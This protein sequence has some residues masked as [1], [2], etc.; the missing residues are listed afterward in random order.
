MSKD[1]PDGSN[2]QDSVVLGDVLSQ[3]GRMR[4]KS[5]SCTLGASEMETIGYTHRSSNTVFRVC[6][7]RWVCL[8]NIRY[9]AYLYSTYWG[10]GYYVVNSFYE[11]WYP[12][13]INWYLT[14]SDFVSSNIVNLDVAEHVFRMYI[15]GMEYAKPTGWIHKPDSYFTVDDSTPAVDQVVVFTE[16]CSYTPT[17]W[18]WAFGDGSTSNEQNPTHAYTV[19]GTYQA[20]L[21]A[22]NAGGQDI[23]TVIITVT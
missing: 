2:I 4:S 16:G 18:F 10:Y 22:T 7:I 13:S 6:G 14:D 3:L 1:S 23:H 19:A 8:D 5:S 12:P 11:L 20:T 17:Q 21:F 15:V 9:S